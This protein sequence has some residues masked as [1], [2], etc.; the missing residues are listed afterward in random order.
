MLRKVPKDL[1]QAPR[2]V[3]H[4]YA[5]KTE[6]S[7]DQHGCQHIVV[8]GRKGDHRDSKGDDLAQL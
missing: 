2:L 4:A 7:A 5:Y 8:R 6:I 3:Q 1:M